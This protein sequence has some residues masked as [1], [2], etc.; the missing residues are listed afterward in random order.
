M[1]TKRR[2]EQAGGVDE[3]LKERLRDLAR[4]RHN[5]NKKRFWELV[6]SFPSD[7][8]KS[9]L[10]AA[11]S[12]VYWSRCGGRTRE[13]F[14]RYP[15]EHGDYL[16]RVASSGNITDGCGEPPEPIP[17]GG[18]DHDKWGVLGPPVIVRY[19]PAPAGADPAE[20]C[21]QW[22]A[23]VP[24]SMSFHGGL[25][26]HEDDAPI[27]ALLAVAV[28]VRPLHEYP[29]PPSDAELEALV[30]SAFPRELGG[31]TR[32]VWEEGSGG[33]CPTFVV[34]WKFEWRYFKQSPCVPIVWH[35]PSDDREAKLHDAPRME[36]KNTLLWQWTDWNWGA[37]PDLEFEEASRVALL[38][39]ETNALSN[40]SELAKC[41]GFLASRLE[42]YIGIGYGVLLVY[43]RRRM[44]QQL[45]L[46]MVVGYSR[47]GR[48]SMVTRSHM[49]EE[50]ARIVAA[51][52]VHLPVEGVPET[53]AAYADESA[54]L[55]NLK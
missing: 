30:R 7:V 4:A 11:A 40:L 22:W 37:Q 31:W 51:L 12:S 36:C 8:P 10:A 54:I 16:H 26:R 17:E 43:L 5:G 32:N 19:T 3:E 21:L 52:V 49:P 24:R 35:T 29:A 27:V 20:D 15:D 2:F 9:R 53:I 48:V 45:L 55:I 23:L 1:S 28:A 41:I 39:N 47:M 33:R 42:A 46:E 34:R 18:I 44:K 38:V 14:F 6:A 13:T 25:F 50:T